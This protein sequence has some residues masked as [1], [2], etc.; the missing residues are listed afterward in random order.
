NRAMRPLPDGRGSV[1]ACKDERLS[2]SHASASRFSDIFPPSIWRELGYIFDGQRLLACSAI[3]DF[4]QEDRNMNSLTLLRRMQALMWM[5]GIGV[6]V[7]A[8][9]QSIVLPAG[10]PIPIRLAQSLDTKRHVPG[11]SFLGHTSA[12]VVYRGE[13]VIPRGTPVHG[14]L[15]DA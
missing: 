4:H 7:A 6:A 5:G 9:E 8:A 12:P 2:R 10:T 13:V 11:S 14:H 3:S 15:V 1:S